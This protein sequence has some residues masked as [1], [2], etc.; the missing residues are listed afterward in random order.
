MHC[1]YLTLLLD[2]RQQLHSTE[3]GSLRTIT[4]PFLV[5]TEQLSHIHLITETS[6]MLF[7][8]TPIFRYLSHFIEPL[9][10]LRAA[11]ESLKDLEIYFKTEVI[12]H[13]IQTVMVNRTA[14]AKGFQKLKELQA[15]LQTMLEKLENDLNCEMD[16]LQIL[17]ITRSVQESLSQEEA[18]FFIDFE[19]MFGR[20]LKSLEVC[21]VEM[22]R[23]KYMMKA[24]H[25][26]DPFLSSVTVSPN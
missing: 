13:I 15:D 23:L 4:D 14:L 21:Y 10:R 2:I 9:M 18:S 22:A 5:L 25:L 12:P 8:N 17:R 1:V 24:E 7:I 20:V 6:T 11:L 3:Q 16:S 26:P 19:K